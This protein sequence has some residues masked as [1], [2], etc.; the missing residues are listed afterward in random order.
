MDS[1]NIPTEVRADPW[2]ADWKEIALKTAESG[3]DRR[4]IKA[5]ARTALFIFPNPGGVW[6][7]YSVFTEPVEAGEGGSLSLMVRELPE[8]WVSESGLLRCKKDA[9]IFIPWR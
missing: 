4:R 2:L 7:G 9:W 1:E 6:T 3:F 5:A 8:T